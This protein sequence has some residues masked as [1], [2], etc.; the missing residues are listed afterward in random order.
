MSPDPEV[1]ADGRCAEC[2]GPRRASARKHKLSKLD[3][4]HFRDL[5]EHIALDPFCST[6]C[7][8]AWHG[9]VHVGDRLRLE[10]GMSSDLAA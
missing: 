7:C 8:R 1:R 2:I 3:K 6:E 10:E 4:S 5:A 9:F